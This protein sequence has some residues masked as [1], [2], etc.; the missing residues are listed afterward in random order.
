MLSSA[1][2]SVPPRPRRFDNH[3]RNNVV[4]PK[5][6]GQGG[7]REDKNMNTAVT[8][9]SSSVCRASKVPA[10]SSRSRR[11][12]QGRTSVGQPKV[13]QRKNSTIP[14][15]AKPK[16]KTGHSVSKPGSLPDPNCN[17]PSLPCLCC[18]GH[19]PQDSNSLYNHNYNNNNT[20]AIRK[21]LELQPAQKQ[22]RDQT[23]QKARD[24]K[25]A[26]PNHKQTQQ[27]E[28]QKQQQPNDPPNSQ[29]TQKAEASEDMEHN[30][31]DDEEDD[32]DDDDTLVPSCH[33]CPPSLL[34]FSLTSSTSSSSTSISSCSDFETDGPDALSP[35]SQDLAPEQTSPTNS[36]SSQPQIFPLDAHLSPVP[37]LP[38]CSPDEGYPSARSSP[39][40]DFPEGKGLF[41]QD[42][43]RLD[44]LSLLDS[45]DGLGKNDLFN[46]MVQVARWELEG[47]LELRD[48]FDHLQKL[49][50]VNMQVKIAYLERLQ[51]ARLELGEGDLSDSLDA[52][53]NMD[54]QWKLYKGHEFCDSQEFSDAGVDMTAPSDIDEPS[55]PD[56]LAP[57]PLQPPPRPPKPP[58]RHVDSHTDAHTYVNISINASAHITSSVTSTSSSSTSSFGKICP[59]SSSSSCTSES[60]VIVPPSVPP[61]PLQA[62]PYFTFYSSRP[63]LASPTPPIPPPRRRH[64]ARM[65]ALRAADTQGEESPVSL[66]P[67]TSRPPPLPPPPPAL[68]LPPAI[69]PPPS[70]PPPP[71]FHTL[72]AE[73]RKLLVL[74]GLTQAELLKLS[75]E[76]GV[77]VTG[78]LDDGDDEELSETVAAPERVKGQKER[79]GKEASEEAEIMEDEWSEGDRELSLGLRREIVTGKDAQEKY[80][81]GKMEENREAYRTTSFTEMARR[82]KRNGS[83][84]N[85][86]CNCGHGLDVKPNPESNFSTAHSSTIS[87]VSNCGN[88][89]EY[90]SVADPAPPPP[91]PRPL[92]PCPPALPLSPLKP[93]LTLCTLPANASR[94][95]RFDWLMAFSPETEN[96]PFEI[97][98]PTE[99]SSQKST[100]GSKV[101]TFKE[102]RY[103]SRQNPQP[104]VV[105]PEPD[106]TVITPDPDFLYNLKWRREKTDGDGIQWEYTPQA[107]SAFLQPQPTRSLTIFKE[108]L[109]LTEGGRLPEPCPSQRIGCSTS[110]SNLWTA[111]VEREGKKLKEEEGEVRGTADGGRNWESRTTVSSPP[112]SLTSSHS[113]PAPYFLHSDPQGPLSQQAGFFYGAPPPRPPRHHRHHSDTEARTVPT[114]SV[115]PSLGG[116]RRRADPESSARS[117]PRAGAGGNLDSLYSDIDSLYCADA[118]NNAGS[119]S[120]AEADGELALRPR[121]GFGREGNAVAQ[122]CTTPYKNVDLLCC[123]N[124]VRQADIDPLCYAG[125]DAD[126]PADAH[127]YAG[128]DQNS[129]RLMWRPAY[130]EE[131][132]APPVWYLYSPS[133]CPLHRGAPPRLS[134]IGAISPPQRLGVPVPGA[135]MARLSSPLFPRSHTIPALAAPF[136]YPYL[137]PASATAPLKESHV[138]VVTK[139]PE[140]CPLTVR[141]VSFAGS[142]QQGEAWMAGDGKGPLGGQRLSSLCLNEKRAL[143]SAVSVAVEAILA[144]FSTSRTLV[145]KSFKNQKAQSGDS[146]FNPSLGRLVLQCLCPALYGLLSDG[147]KPHQS[148]LI[149]GRRP[150]SPWGLVQ[151]STRQ[152]PRTQALYSLQCRVAELPQLRQS[153][154]RFNA[155]LLG[156]LNVKL[157]D[158]WLSH[159][160]SCDDVLA[161]YYRP[162]SFMRLSRTSCQPLFEELI[163]LLQPLSLL[164]FN[165]DLL[166]QHHHLDPA[167]PGLSS[168]NRSPE[169][170]SPA[171]HESSFRVPPRGFSIDSRHPLESVS[172]QDFRNLEPAEDTQHAVPTA[173]ANQ[174]AGEVEGFANHSPFPGTV[175]NTGETSPQL[176]WLQE[177][178]IV[179]P[180]VSNFSQQAGQAIQQGW[181][182]MLRWSERLGQNLGN[183][184]ATGAVTSEL[185]KPLP[186]P[187]DFWSGSSSNTLTQPDLISCETQKDPPSESSPTVPW[188]LGRLFGA[189]RGQ[190]SPQ[191]RTPT[192]RRPSHWLAPGVSALTRIVSP[193]QN[194]VPREGRGEEESKGPREAEETGER[195]RPLRLV[196]TL[197]DHMGTGEELSFQKGEELM[198]LEGVDS[199]WV[200][201]RRDDKEGLVPIGYT[202]LIM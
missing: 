48:R 69:P 166:F 24:T 4:D 51:E 33:D 70:L 116:S 93:A 159:L 27:Q 92:P 183:Y 106:P 100:S 152:G 126:G 110:E 144:Q 154:H 98:K 164:T 6:L 182:A 13:D 121:P 177:K 1:R 141:S 194:P 173:L 71:S 10:E 195:P 153:R 77:C 32:D 175:S 181:G 111:G 142:I 38:P 64:K 30:E 65:E 143:L 96:P 138:P 25:K 40:S 108:I 125:R 155:F 21:K 146:S 79:V 140:L 95:D 56:S 198:V 128:V 123:P 105:Q 113:P 86:S 7:R 149:A 162:S 26:E 101:T 3:K 176:M 42:C 104:A 197:C 127:G 169:T 201:C 200:R 147:L 36:L 29:E 132:P 76:L 2:P 14:V 148:D 156:L 170:P 124:T 191:T 89:Y 185:E 81:E 145:Q 35:P 31:G 11:G 137:K 199:D 63:C 94:P 46:Q 187:Q 68:P 178:E 171:N 66:P 136:Y 202:S 16:P 179:P 53:E 186:R 12:D 57:S 129:N 84:S 83:N 34:Q 23:P 39:S 88:T 44:L 67:P 59:S 17:E 45:M 102:L 174:I 189:P 58:T 60:E 5:S 184:Y 150:N 118:N 80:L 87:S 120:C 54:T 43:T 130:A 107:H 72:D 75:P 190:R 117:L 61:P 196:R 161:T 9:A 167:S 97:E 62:L 85:Y 139:Q 192:A 122:L 165:L 50:Q 180:S 114:A 28:P 112:L 109:K 22:S 52:L 193:T 168:A 131:C 47:D 19:S 151:A 41:R 90:N 115:A 135:D 160:Q 82:R 188:G 78:V 49:E 91:P 157:L 119:P 172:E 133:N 74:A 158:Y 99:G 163:L 73:I 55:L 18:D 8:A 15:R 20:I 37:P 134:P 103:R